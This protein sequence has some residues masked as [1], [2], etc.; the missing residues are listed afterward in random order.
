MSDENQFE[1]ICYNLHGLQTKDPLQFIKSCTYLISQSK[2]L[3]FRTIVVNKLDSLIQ[4][5]TQKSQLSDKE[6]NLKFY[7]IDEHKKGCF[8]I[9]LEEN[10]LTEEINANTENIRHFSSSLLKELAIT[11][12]S[13]FLDIFLPYSWRDLF[14]GRTPEKLEVG[15]Y[16]FQLFEPTIY[17]NDVKI[18]VYIARLLDIMNYEDITLKITAIQTLTKYVRHCTNFHKAQFLHP[19]FQNTLKLILSQNKQVLNSSCILLIKIFD[20]F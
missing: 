16:L 5:L 9:S 17:N 8:F 15:M 11:F 6:R 2:T 10:T 13:Y 20:I 4:L 19:V 1:Q 14:L 18:H 3:N 7:D 12:D